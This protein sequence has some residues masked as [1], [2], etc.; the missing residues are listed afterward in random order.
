[1]E[2]VKYMEKERKLKK[3]SGGVATGSEGV[4]VCGWWEREAEGAG[5]GVG[6]RRYLN[7]PK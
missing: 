3:T 6:G 4:S 5:E 2:G 1:M 7:I